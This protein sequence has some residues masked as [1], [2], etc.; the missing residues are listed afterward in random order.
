MTKKDIVIF[1]NIFLLAI[2]SLIGKEKVDDFRDEV[3]RI[4]SESRDYSE[5]W[6]NFCRFRLSANN[7]SLFRNF[8]EYLSKVEKVLDFK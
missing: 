4:L 1:L 2:Q 8:A 6:S 7:S 5:F 3:Y